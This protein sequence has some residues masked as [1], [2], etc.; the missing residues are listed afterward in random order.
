[1]RRGDINLFFVA[2]AGQGEFPTT[3]QAFF[4]EVN[5]SSPDLRRKGGADDMPP[6]RFGVFGL[7]NTAYEEFNY[8]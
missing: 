1:M 8:A 4:D 2:T 6:F 3:S 5:R 7:G